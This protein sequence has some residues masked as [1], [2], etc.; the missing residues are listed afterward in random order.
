MCKEVAIVKAD[1][2]FDIAENKEQIERLLGGPVPGL[3][4][5][6]GTS[7][8]CPIDAEATA[9]RYGFTVSAGWDTHDCDLVMTSLS[10]H[11]AGAAGAVPDAGKVDS[12]QQMA[13]EHPPIEW[14]ELPGSYTNYGDARPGDWSAAVPPGGWVLP[15]LEELQATVPAPEQGRYWTA[16]EVRGFFDG[17]IYA[18]FP[19]GPNGARYGAR[20]FGDEPYKVR[21]I[22]RP[23]SVQHPEQ[24]AASAPNGR[25]RRVTADGDRG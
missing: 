4:G 13:A 21:L 9:A 3:E 24:P 11:T 6:P 19:P 17:N 5:A 25:P 23:P 8:L 20:Y 7:C 10:A 2:T 15:T 16:S 12:A 14:M 22:K 1:G 18:E